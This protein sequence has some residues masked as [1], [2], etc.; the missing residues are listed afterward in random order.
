VRNDTIVRQYG[1]ARS[2][3]ARV[4]KETL[5]QKRKGSRRIAEIVE[6]EINRVVRKSDVL[7][8]AIHFECIRQGGMYG[9]QRCRG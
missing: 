7:E 3:L 8:G 9:K 1:D 4:F 5:K 2:Y 6:W